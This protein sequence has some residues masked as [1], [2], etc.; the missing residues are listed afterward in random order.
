M[1]PLQYWLEAIADPRFSP[2]PIFR[3]FLEEYEYTEVIRLMARFGIQLRKSERE[4]APGP[5]QPDD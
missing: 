5:E 1:A 2:K 4:A 3:D